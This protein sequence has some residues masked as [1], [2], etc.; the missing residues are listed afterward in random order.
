MKKAIIFAVVGFVVALAASTFLGLQKA[1][2]AAA[3]AALVV[4]AHADSLKAAHAADSTA[5]TDSS[6]KHEGGEHA[7]GP[8]DSTATAGPGDAPV[9]HGEPADPATPKVIP[10]STKVD[11]AEKAEAFKQ[12]ARVLSAMKAAEAVK[13]MAFLSDDEVE[14]ILRAVGPR[15]AGDFLTNLP[16]ERAANLSRRLLVPKPK[17]GQ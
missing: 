13:V 14:G 6:A 2:K 5:A 8:K 16:K 11:P 10:A 15:Q 17:V 12:V 1:K 7:E 3:A 9:A 4:A